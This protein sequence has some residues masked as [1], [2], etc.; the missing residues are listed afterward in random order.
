MNMKFW[1]Q[2]WSMCMCHA[3][4]NLQCLCR[5]WEI[6]IA[7]ARLSGQRLN[8]RNYYQLSMLIATCV[9]PRVPNIPCTFFAKHPCEVLMHAC[10]PICHT[11]DLLHPLTCNYHMMTQE[12]HLLLNQAHLSTPA[13]SCL[14]ELARIQI[15]TQ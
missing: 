5:A 4:F 1:S 7:E 12:P 11:G 3:L 8:A 6:L 10:M 13:T 9:K 2:I 14:R 15:E